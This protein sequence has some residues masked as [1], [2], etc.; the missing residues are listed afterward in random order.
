VR[1]GRG[2]YDRAG[3]RQRL[4]CTHRR[5]SDVAL[6]EFTTQIP[7]GSASPMLAPAPQLGKLGM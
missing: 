1:G 2:L 5:Q 4:G 7:N 3:R 6:G